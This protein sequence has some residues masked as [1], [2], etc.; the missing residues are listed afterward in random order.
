MYADVLCTPT[1]YIPTSPT[2]YTILLCVFEDVR[3][4]LSINRIFD[5]F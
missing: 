2:F 4:P 5:A 1:F 3:G